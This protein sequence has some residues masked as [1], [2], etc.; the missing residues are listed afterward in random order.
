MNLIAFVEQKLCQ[1]GSILPGNAG[2]QS[3]FCQVNPCN[4]VKLLICNEWLRLYSSDI[5]RQMLPK[6]SYNESLLIQHKLSCLVSAECGRWG[7]LV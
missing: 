7:F 4:I 5:F 1:I 3:N 2:D 6:R